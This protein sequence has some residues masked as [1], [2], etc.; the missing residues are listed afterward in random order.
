[1]EWSTRSVP[2]PEHLEILRNKLFTSNL[3]KIVQRSSNKPFLPPG[4]LSSLK[5]LLIFKEL[6]GEMY[7]S[8]FLLL[9]LS[10]STMNMNY[11]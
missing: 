7:D 5:V 4:K 2:T 1:M 8:K 11:F 6:L 9:C 10:Y 3:L